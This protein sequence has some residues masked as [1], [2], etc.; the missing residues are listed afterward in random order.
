MEKSY[1]KVSTLI[2]EKILAGELVPGDHLPPEREMAELLDTSRNSVREGLRV[3]ENVGV[4]ESRQGS[5]NYISGRFEETLTEVMS[6][7]YVMKGMKDSEITE[8]RYALEWQAMNLAA[9]R[10]TEGQ[11]KRLMRHLAALEAAETEAERSA[12]DKAI[13][14][15]L[16]EASGNNYMI[17]SYNAIVRIMDIYIPKMRGKIIMGMQ[18]DTELSKAH[19]M[20]AE[21]AAEG[22]LDKGL[23]GLELHFKY[24]KEYQDS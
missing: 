10:I 17:A 3:L 21:G 4:I 5:G 2:K 8:F 13:H 6:F 7:M 18:D 24:I 23:G 22:D 12:Q 1:A 19:R 14:Y 20:I 16:M 15:V 9:E 11:K